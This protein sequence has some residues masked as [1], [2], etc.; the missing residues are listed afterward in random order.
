MKK[1]FIVFVSLIIIAGGLSAQ[2]SATI[3]N[4]GSFNPKATDSGFIFGVGQSRIFDERVELGFSIDFF[5][6]KYTDQKTVD[7]V[8]TGGGTTYTTEQMLLETNTIFVPIL[9]NLTVKMPVEFPII[10]YIGVGIGYS[11]LWDTY[12][13][14]ELDIKDTKFFS[15]FGWRLAAGGLYP[16]GSRSAL[17]CEVMYNGGKPSR[18]EDAEFGLPTWQEVDMSGLGFRLGIKLFR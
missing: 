11:L 15:G 4:I 2:E 6:N 18:S 7:T 1:I 14:Y 10:P 13:N 5:S 3:I 17:T 12:S 8:T 9:A 16:L